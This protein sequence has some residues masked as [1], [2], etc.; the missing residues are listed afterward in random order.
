MKIRG[1]VVVHDDTC[2]YCPVCAENNTT[3][4][5]WDDN[6]KVLFF[7]CKTCEDNR[8]ISLKKDDR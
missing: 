6:I 8:W 5:V 2:P 4:I 7:Y 1:G 3:D